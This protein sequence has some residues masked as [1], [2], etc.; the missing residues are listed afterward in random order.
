MS[1]VMPITA[2]DIAT[3]LDTQDDFDLELFVHRSLT[4]SGFQS[5][6]AGTYSDPVTGGPRQF[7]VRARRFF[8]RR[9]WQILLAVQCEKLSADFPLLVSRVPRPI[10]ESYHEVIRSWERRETGEDFVEAVRWERG[11]ELYPENE[12]VGKKI[13]RVRN[14]AADEGFRDT[15]DGSYGEW[16]EALVS[17]A[18]LVREGILAHRG[19][20][21]S[22]YFTLVLPVLVVSDDSLW[23]VDYSESGRRA[24]SALPVEETEVY[25]GREYELLAGR[26]Y[27]V[28][29]LHLF[30]RSGFTSFLSEL[31]TPG[32]MLLERMF[33]F[34]TLRSARS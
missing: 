31:S 1:G 12:L 2:K 22:E 32:A 7:D 15:G 21:V 16:S 25:V 14:P 17:A 28:S 9:R 8:P 26:R 34:T 5:E 24:R 19:H 29:H 10:Q 30:T 18:D 3:F 23:V 4:A 6:H 20:A 27:Q 13:V 33:Q 11:P